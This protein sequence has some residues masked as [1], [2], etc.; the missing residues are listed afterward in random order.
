MSDDTISL[1]RIFPVKGLN[2][3]DTYAFTSTPFTSS[4]GFVVQADPAKLALLPHKEGYK[5]ETL[6]PILDD[7]KFNKIFNASAACP[8]EMPSIAIGFN[9]D[10]VCYNRP[11]LVESSKR[12]IQ[13]LPA[14][15][16]GSED[17][18]HSLFIAY[19]QKLDYA[20]L[21]EFRE[22]RPA[23]LPYNRQEYTQAYP[24][25]TMI[26]ALNEYIRQASSRYFQGSENES[27]YNDFQSCRDKME[28]VIAN[29]ADYVSV[30]RHW[31]GASILDSLYDYDAVRG[32]RLGEEKPDAL[33]LLHRF[34][35]LH[36]CHV[37]REKIEARGNIVIQAQEPKLYEHASRIAEA[38]VTNREAMEL[39][40]TQ[41]SEK[42]IGFMNGLLAGQ[43]K[44]RPGF[45]PTLS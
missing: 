31:D 12:G 21:A 1:R 35:R 22:E 16:I 9:N 3:N 23:H 2:E 20:P 36:E 7:Y 8:I 4:T 28:E 41:L 18:M 37:Y 30:V 32:M 27:F 13:K 5:R 15:I 42:T 38:I 34:A 45:E 19:G 26:I 11:L 6:G 44:Y 24:I 10:I 17:D 25:D 40:Q 33:D 39:A 29:G 43:S 14:Q